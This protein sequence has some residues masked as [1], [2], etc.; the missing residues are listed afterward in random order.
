[1]KIMKGIGIIVLFMILTACT[2]RE[3]N[4]ETNR[5]SGVIAI[6]QPATS[7]TSN[8][9]YGFP[10][11]FSTV[12]IE[13]PLTKT[14]LTNL[15]PIVEKKQINDEVVYLYQKEKENLYAAIQSDSTV[16]DIG[17]IGYS[18]QQKDSIS[19]EQVEVFGEAYI[20]MTGFCGANCPITNYVQIE[21]NPS[22]FL[23][24]TA[25][26]VEADINQER[27]EAFLLIFFILSFYTE[28]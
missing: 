2:V 24:M 6:Q 17:Q 10:L 19:I 13:Q 7:M 9:S 15:G 26:T 20:K 23:Q 21:Q 16:F 18:L 8:V 28:E 4:Q 27:I 22:S 12:K 14:T 3:N 25:H 1:M 5:S 11:L